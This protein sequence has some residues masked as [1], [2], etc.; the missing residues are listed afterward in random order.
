MATDVGALNAIGVKVWVL[1][2]GLTGGNSLMKFEEIM[3][4]S[5]IDNEA[6]LDS[7]V[8]GDVELISQI[9]LGAD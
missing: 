6:I 5:K 7:I 8:N 4:K 9:K 2:D 1:A 3:L